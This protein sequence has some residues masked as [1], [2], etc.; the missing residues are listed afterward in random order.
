MNGA[1]SLARITTMAISTMAIS[2]MAIS[3]VHGTVRLKWSWIF[4]IV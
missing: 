3:T 1:I 4:I 2:T